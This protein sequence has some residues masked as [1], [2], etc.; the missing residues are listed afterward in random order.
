MAVNT[1]KTNAKWI[2]VILEDSGGSDQDISAAVT[3]VNIP[4]IYSEQDVTGFSDG[5]TNVSIG[6]PGMNVTMDG[7]FSNTASTGAHIVLSGIVGLSDNSSDNSPYTL[8]VRVGIRKAPETDDPEFEGVFYCL[9]YNVNGDLTWNA[10]FQPGS[11]TAP[12]WI[13]M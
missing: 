1:G 2:R 5:V 4:I 12:A 7:V 3:N 13:T 9:S 8:T 11:G 6:H 10:T